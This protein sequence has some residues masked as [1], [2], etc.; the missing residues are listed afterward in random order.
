MSL[1]DKAAGGAGVITVCEHKLRSVTEQENVFD[2]YGRDVTREVISV[3]R[4][5]GG[6]AQ[7]ELF[8]HAF[9]EKGGA[10]PGP[11]DGVHHTGGPMREMSKAEMQAIIADFGQYARQ[12]RDFGFDMVML[13]FGHDSLCSVFMSPVWNQRTDEYGGSLENRT[14]FPREAIRAIREAVGPKFPIMVRISRQLMVPETY[15]E[16]DMLYFIQSIQDDVDIVN[17]SAGMDCYGGTIDKYVANNYA[18]PSIFLPR[19][20][21]LDFCERVKQECDVKVCIVGGVSEPEACEAAIAEG[22]VDLVMLGRQLV[23]DPFWPKKAMEGREKEIVPCLRCLNCYHIATV[24]ANV[25]CS[26]NPRFR[27]ENR[28]PLELSE[29]KSPKRVV[30]IGGGPAGMKAALVADERGHQAT[31]IEKGPELG[32]NLKFADYGEFKEDV[33]KYREHL[34]YMLTQSKVDV[35]LNTTATIELVESLEPEAVIVAVGADFIT[36][37]IPGVEHAVQ[38]AGIYPKLDEIDGDVVII[39]GGSIGSELGLELAM[40]KNKVTVVEQNSALAERSNWLYRHGLYNAIKDYTNAVDFTAM[41]ET[42]VKEIKADGVVTVDKDGKEEFVP[43]K[44]ILLAVGTKP[45][46]E[47]AI[48]FYGITPETSMVGDC[49]KAAQILETTNDAYFIAANL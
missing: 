20:Y 45:K 21:N 10:I 6:L 4:Q 18:M 19:M 3:M 29:S 31:L 14:R 34:K 48:S 1:M 25:Q 47:L 2:K 40:R 44:Y 11:S 23:A 12:A 13:H 30:I 16:D 36:P 26:V 38:A 49:Y 28:V 15:T 24:H 33:R 5:A 46:K 35:K 39:G 32:G 17:V 43:A 37:N 9:P 7:L 22:K 8:F 27:R 41:L 42:S